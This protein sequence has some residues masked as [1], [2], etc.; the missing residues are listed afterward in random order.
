MRNTLH[1]IVSLSLLV[2]LFFYPEVILAA[3]IAQNDTLQSTNMLKIQPGM[4]PAVLAG[5]P[6]NELVLLPSGR[7]LSIA[8]LQ[9]FSAISK[10]LR[11]VKNQPMRMG[12]KFQ[13]AASG[14][15]VKNGADLSA[16][17]KRSDSET[18][19]LPSGKLV[20]VELLRYLQPEVDRRI[21][22]NIA[23]TTERYDSGSKPIAI[24]STTD[25]EYWKEILL[26]PDST[27]LEA[28]DGQ[29]ITVGELKQS[30]GG[31]SPRDKGNANS[32]IKPKQ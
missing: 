11:Q 26:K 25:K 22:R 21:G 17:L 24:K 3:D 15:Q 4:S 14:I 30:L 1:L 2:T 9:K 19:E 18:V 5:R 29:R 8:K 20:T 13:P 27:V 16:A 6:G 32:S 12:L 10:K 7:K 31:P 23:I 28:P